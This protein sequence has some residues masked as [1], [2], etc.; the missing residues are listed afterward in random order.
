[1]R[2]RS[3][4][5]IC[6]IYVTS[7]LHKYIDFH[8]DVWIFHLQMVVSNDQ[9]IKTMHETS[10]RGVEDM[11]TLVDLHEHTILR[12][13]HIR[14]NENLI[15]TYTGS[16]LVAVNP[17]QP[18]PIYTGDYVKE[19]KGQKVGDKPP[20][21]FAIGDSSY[22]DM[23][24]FG[25]NQ[26]IVISG[27]SGAGK[28][29]STKLI[30]QYLA[31]ISG[32][33]SWIEQQIL[34]AN[35]VLEAFG[36]AKTIRN[37]NSSRF[38]KYININFSQECV[39]EGAAIE[40]YLLEKSRIVSQNNGERNY[41]IFYEMLAGLTIDEKISL[42]LRGPADYRYLTGGGTLTCEGRDDAKDFA[43]VRAAMKVLNFNENEVWEIIKLLAVV[44]HLGN[45]KYKARVIAN[46]D[47][48]EI[49]DKVHAKKIADILGV[50]IEPLIEALTH[51][52]IFAHGE[53]VVSALSETQA[54]EVRDAFVKGI[55][56]R[57]FIYIVNKINNTV[58]KQDIPTKN[59]IGVLD[60]FGFENFKSNSFEQLCINYA[61]ENLQQF[62][63]R[64][65]FKLE[66]EEYTQEGINWKHMEFVDNQEILDLIGM[67]PINIMAL[68]DEESKFPKGTDK[69]MLNKVHR[70]HGSDKYF[71][72]PI[73]EHEQVF[74]LNHFAGTVYYDVNGF[75]EKNRDTFSADL[76]QVVYISSNKFLKTLFAEDFNL[77]DD[78][79]KRNLTL[80]VQFRK[81]LEALMHTLSCCHPW[82]V[83]CMKPNEFKKPK[84]FD[85]TLV[86]RQ[87]RYSG[88][89]ETARI[90]RAGY[91]IRHTFKEFV[92]RYRF[93]APGIPPSNK[94]DCKAAS[95]KICAAVLTKEDYQLGH[96]KVF[97]KDAHDS[98]LEEAR[99]KA[100]A[101]SILVLQRNVR[102]WVQR[103]RY[104]ALRKAAVVFQKHWRARGPRIHYR[105]IR[106]GYLR[107]QALIRS[108]QLRHQFKL[109]ST[110][111]TR[112][113]E[114]Q[115][116]IVKHRRNEEKPK[117][118]DMKCRKGIERNNYNWD[119]DSR[120][121][122]FTVTF[123][124]S[125]RIFWF[126]KQPSDKRFLLAVDVAIYNKKCESPFLFSILNVDEN[127]GNETDLAAMII[128]MLIIK[129]ML[130]VYESIS[131][132]SSARC[133]GYLARK[134]FKE[135]SQ[136]RFV[137]SVCIIP[138][139]FCFKCIC[140]SIECNLIGT[141]EPQIILQSSSQK[142]SLKSSFVLEL[143]L[144][145][146]NTFTLSNFIKLVTFTV[147]AC[148]E[149]P[150]SL[151]RMLN[152]HY[153]CTYSFTH[154]FTSSTSRTTLMSFW[155]MFSCS[156]ADMM[157]LEV[158]LIKTYSERFLLIK[159]F[160][161]E[162]MV[163]QL[164]CVIVPYYQLLLVYQ[165][166]IL[167]LA[168]YMFTILALYFQQPV[169]ELISIVLELM[170]V[171]HIAATGLFGNLCSVQLLKVSPWTPFSIKSG[172]ILAECEK[173]FNFQV[174][175]CHPWSKLLLKPLRLNNH[176]ATIFVLFKKKQQE[177][178]TLRE[179]EEMQLK[180][181]GTKN[182]K[183][184]AEQNYKK[185]LS[186]FLEEMQTREYGHA[187][188][189]EAFDEDSN[190]YS[191]I[192]DELFDFDHQET[193]ELTDKHI[194]GKVDILQPDEGP[195]EDLSEYNFRK[196]AATYF[197]GNITY[198]Y[199]RRPI[200]HSL[201]ELPVEAD[202]LAAKALWITILRFMG[203]LP[204]PRNVEVDNTPV[205]SRV[206]TTLTR[207]FINSKEY[208]KAQAI[209]QDIGTENLKSKNNSE[210]KRK[211][212]IS[213][214]LK[215]TNKLA[216]HVRRGLL[217][218]EYLDDGYSDWLES[219][220]T[221]NLEKLH[222]IIGH[223][224]LRP[225]LR[226]EIFCQICKQLTNNPTKASHARGW[227]LLS[228]CV[229]CFPPSENFAMY[230]KA[231]IRDGPPGYAPY[232]ERRLNRTVAN[233]S[234]TQ[235]PS[236]I[237][238][239]ATKAKKPMIVQITFMD[240]SYKNVEIDSATTAEELCD[241]LSQNI[242][243]T[244]TFGFSVFVS[245]MDK[246]TSI[247]ST[248][249]HVMDVIS[250]CE[251]YAKEKGVPEKNAQWRLYFRKEI[252]APWHN[253]ADDSVATNLIYHQVVRGAMFGEYRCDKESD[254][255][256]M[257]AQQ[258]Y[259][260]YGTNMDE[261]ILSTQLP[262]YIPS[263]IWKIDPDNILPHWG[264]LVLDAY[265]KSY[266]V[267]DTVPASKVKEDVVTFAKIKWPLLF[268]KFFQAQR[269]GGSELHKNNIIIA[270]NWTGVYFIDDQEEVILELSYPEVSS[271]TSHKKIYGIPQNF[272]LTTTQGLSFEFKSPLS[273]EVESV[274]N[275]LLDGLKKRSKFVVATQDYIPDSGS[276]FLIL[277]R[278][279]LL[280]L[281]EEFDGD[282]IMNSSWGNG[283]NAR[284][285]QRGHFPTEVIYV[286][287]AVVRPAPN[288]VAIFEKDPVLRMK[289]QQFRINTVT[290]QRMY[291]LKEFAKDHFRESQSVAP[292]KG[293]TLKEARRVGIEELWRH[294]REPIKLALLKKV[295]DNSDLSNTACIAFTNILKYM[296]DQPSKRPHN[297]S[298][299]TDKIFSCALKYD[300]LKDEI[301]CQIMRQLTDNKNR[302]S[303]ERGWELMWLATGLFCCSKILLKDL[304]QFLMTRSHPIAKTCINRLQRTMRYG[305]RKHPPHQ[306]EVEAIQHKT[307]RIFHKVYFP[308]D[309]DEAFQVDSTTRAEDFSRNV[310]ERLK[311]QS[312]EGFSLFVKVWDKVFSVPENDFFFDFVHELTQW[313]RKA[314][315]SRNESAVQFQY[316]IFF[317]R[318][319][320]INVVP[321]KDKYADTIFH[322]PQEIPKYL[323]GYH[324]CSKADTIKLAAL[325]YRAKF[326][327][328]TLQLQFIPD[329]LSTL[330]PNDLHKLQSASD[331]KKSI[332]SAYKQ[333]AGM[334][335][336]AAKQA[337][338]TY[339]YKWPTFGSAFFD[340]KQATEPK[341]P[342]VIIVG[343]NK[344]GISIIHPTT[345][346]LL[347]THP[348]SQISNWSSGN[349]FFHVTIGDLVRGSKLLCE[350]SLGYKMDDLL[351][352]YTS[353][354]QSAV[355]KKTRVATQL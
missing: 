347:D 30:L 273:A 332:S 1:M 324:K 304:M 234:R 52:T 164:K 314:R 145:S 76:K 210:N 225:D 276:S 222:F 270:V 310:A 197:Q 139:N 295:A 144:L 39:I 280:I 73:S 125:Y 249:E 223:G 21:I 96:T 71:L 227:V 87:L 338:L 172:R 147:R 291:V 262:N 221:T 318:K 340:V 253:T 189:P 205:M 121:F 84:L 218:D 2:S 20:H 297:G 329:M 191:R 98:I 255:A 68:I 199:S 246:V 180:N 128:Y 9:I 260:E 211:K 309:S 58:N 207:N 306:V 14:Y 151:T 239:Q 25:R 64:H 155:V 345:K 288:I 40:Q 167:E 287:P 355:H 254:I 111:I 267:K 242:G 100:L 183:A 60:I 37:D 169:L 140:S 23:A 271:V 339:I 107:L 294:T 90:R 54:T 195:K 320:W 206:T 32:K 38:G 230:L 238:M 181:S 219:R 269:V 220:R 5:V 89:M 49:P 131:T 252:F 290:R 115:N 74:G 56:G 117:W 326:G 257:A 6:G 268:S 346:D 15:Y 336:D 215:N 127:V 129:M 148:C 120:V 124:Y 103:R 328:N 157:T 264:R 97:L 102:G 212:L 34:E 78:T 11:I 177:L 61:N 208:K 348:Y 330:V 277:K 247:G 62:F 48:S 10:V 302:L 240:G 171:I 217:S 266:Y 351:S 184:I 45:I 224:I 281:E 299:F 279:D 331:W 263:H 248:K 3:S 313:M 289:E 298:E 228:L 232:C 176:V 353:V 44:L 159:L 65:I 126:I 321:G 88:M 204:E 106:Q 174:T 123:W 186:E 69:T 265:Q 350:T 12:N 119:L 327:D 149:H 116:T 282:K 286:L 146:L 275:F 28:T 201:L 132:V 85:R 243:L 105:T 344:N 143:L 53:K 333:N 300:I 141:S 305:Q 59:S 256:M 113:Q 261:K 36:N 231:F 110:H 13:L 194:D 192:V 63:V 354:I 75:L 136:A 22:T 163:E 18:L 80:S 35:P 72:K 33:H 95:G 241:N 16:I 41:H 91:P 142:H 188:Q 46:I 272:T 259:I 245:V 233:G 185:R 19:Y 178:Y 209:Y 296:G 198:Q 203:D 138:K 311:L 166:R 154:S 134:M 43:V 323:R 133:R 118:E 51:K 325:I 285:G 216:A 50:P 101:N 170:E 307:T 193:Q 161:Q 229:G 17:Y 29:E 214:T 235:P 278:G 284:T 343:I 109:V 156:I 67:K 7:V 122:L 322:Y 274:I 104:L 160:Y 226:D 158:L 352:S 301:Y 337:F 213:M 57:V 99:E 303:E 70:N 175:G 8:I 27:E 83:R 179:K 236:W 86:V 130:S 112:L 316:Q 114:L 293:Q 250:Q 66:Q 168:S 108:R 196:F 182:Y 173:Q 77:T 81:S 31:A 319:L 93:I 94:T 202:E 92:E 162:M 251:Q 349:T 152:I 165:T 317:M 341:Y 55:Y 312:W 200:K 308:D 334:T 244:D 153:N 335:A 283:I 237:E 47:T 135:K 42:D 24:K 187:V 315:P 258:Y 342:E 79:R 4:L 292:P 26:C 137:P 190:E 150:K 82:F